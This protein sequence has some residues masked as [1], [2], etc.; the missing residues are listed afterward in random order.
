L[1]S[2]GFAVL[3][4]VVAFLGGDAT[5]RDRLYTGTP[6]FKVW[7][8]LII[9]I[10]GALPAAWRVGVD[11]LRRLGLDPRRVLRSWAAPILAAVLLVAAA[12]VLGGRYLSV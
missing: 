12:A 9:G 11:L 6:E 5:A 2:A 10:V 1:L 8:A 4:A 7:A 3:G